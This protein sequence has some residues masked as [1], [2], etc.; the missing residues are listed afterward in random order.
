MLELKGRL[1]KHDPAIL[2][3]E[4]GPTTYRKI[5]ESVRHEIVKFDVMHWTGRGVI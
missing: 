2:S 4:A 5:L 1:M 3:E